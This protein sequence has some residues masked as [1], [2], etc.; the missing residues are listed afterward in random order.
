MLEASLEEQAKIAAFFL[1]QCKE[2]IPALAT[3]LSDGGETYI[4]QMDFLLS[5]CYFV[6]GGNISI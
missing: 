6:F 4:F 1:K 2:F 3:N 5:S